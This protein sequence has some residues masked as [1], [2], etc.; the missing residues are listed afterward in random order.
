M[1]DTETVHKIKEVYYKDDS[2][3]AIIEL[4]ESVNKCSED[5]QK[6]KCWPIK[7][8]NLPENDLEIKLN[9]YGRAL[10]RNI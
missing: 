10:G 2:D 5:T 9:Q 4:Q 1:R 7:A 3:I 6:D 8:I